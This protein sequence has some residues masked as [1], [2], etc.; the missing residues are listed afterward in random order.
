MQPWRF[1]STGVRTSTWNPCVVSAHCVAPCVKRA[2]GVHF[3]RRGPAEGEWSH[4]EPLDGA[5]VFQSPESLAG[6]LVVDGEMV[7][8]GNSEA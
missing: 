1:V 4:A 5:V 3:G 2:G 6:G 7:E 8:Y